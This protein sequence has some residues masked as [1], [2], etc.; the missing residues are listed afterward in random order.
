[1]ARI[2]LPSVQYD[3]DEVGYN[4]RMVNVLA[5]LGVAQLELM[6]EFFET[7]RKNLARYVE[8]IKDIPHFDMHTEPLNVKS[9]YWMYCLVVDPQH[10]TI[11]KQ[12]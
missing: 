2:F 1:M 11:H 9:N 12:S 6:P 10:R 5:A 7:K 8:L 3:H 4:Y